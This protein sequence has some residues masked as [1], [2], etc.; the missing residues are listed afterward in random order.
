MSPQAVTIAVVIP[1]YNCSEF[2]IRSLEALARSADPPDECIVVDDGSNDGTAEAVRS[3]SAPGLIVKVM[4]TG[5]RRGPAHARNIGARAS[6]SS[7]L[8][9]IDSDVCVHSGT[10]GG[11]R[12]AFEHDS[13]LA[14]LIGCYDDSPE[15]QDF[16]SQYKNL[17]HHHVHQRARESATTFWSGCGA[18]RRPVFLEMTGFNEVQYQRPSIEDI[19]LG[20]RMRSSGHKMI[21]DREIQVKHLKRWTFWNLVKTDIRDRGIPWTELILRDQNMPDDLN[22][23]VSQR[24]SVALAFLLLLG[25]VALAVK[26]GAFFLVPLFAAVMLMVGRWWVE[27]AASR[28]KLVV[29]GMTAAMGAL[30]VLCKIYHLLA[31]IP[32]LVLAYG[33]LFLRHRYSSGGRGARMIAVFTAFYL[34]FSVVSTLV[35]L[36][37]HWLVQV[38]LVGLLGVVILN[39]HFYLFLAEKRGRLFAVAAIPL[40]L[41]YHLY[42]ALSFAIGM[43]RFFWGKFRLSSASIRT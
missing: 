16:V 7:V 42:N 24:I 10:L 6:S 14:A 30:I 5:G 43:G 28:N 20:Y 1:A 39:G 4:T 11:I 3:F 33:L 15:N 19:E 29:V 31:L 9:F 18:V 32:I 17:M 41:L 26:W 25:D 37:S 13:E 12:R 23:E 35:F 40:H 2:L 8:W 27:A 21:L 34:G 38:F 36:P 22:L